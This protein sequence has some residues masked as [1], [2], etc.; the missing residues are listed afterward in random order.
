MSV[1]KLQALLAE[2]EAYF[3]VSPENR[4][5]LTGFSSSDGY[6]LITRD[7][8]VFLAD[9][10]YIEAAKKR[11]SVCNEVLQFVRADLELPALADKLGVK[12]LFIESSRI[13]V[14]RFLRIKEA[15]Q[16]IC[17][18]CSSRA[19]S[20]IEALRLIKSREEV[21]SILAAQGIAENAFTH[22]LGYIRTGVT[23]RE[24]AL[25]LD[26]HML[27]ARSE[28]VS[29]DTIAVSGE[30]SSMPHG[31]PG[32][33]Q[34]QSGDFITLDFGAV[35]NGYH[36][37]MTRTVALGGISCEQGRIYNT[38]LLAQQASIDIIKAGVSCS[39][40]DAAARDII[41]SEGFGENF[42]HGTGHG[43]GVEIHEAP[44]VSQRSQ[45]E[46]CAGNIVTVEPGIYIPGKF[47]VRIE[48]MVLV[49]DNGN[50][51]LTKSPKTLIVLPV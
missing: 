10:R 6:L 22:I 35:I 21:N 32:D 11:I 50:E 41:T 24:I 25:E 51:N 17:V 46:L 45:E 13:S 3:I 44:S 36:S 30:N 43:V 19:D 37:D 29:F 34:I 8:S 4:L 33:R 27:I 16:G 14:K 48:D 26:R 28:G 42:G 39:S 1:K 5:Y 18:D 9:S 12:T 23:E 31:V 15:F 20:D 2:G 38:V 7:T 47:G 49:T 40:A